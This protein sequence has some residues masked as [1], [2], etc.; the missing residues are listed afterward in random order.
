MYLTKWEEKALQGEFGE[1]LEISM[2]TLV[3]VCKTLKAEKLIEV[4]HAHISGV[5]YFNIGDE[6][7]EFLEDLAKKG[8][9]VSVY[10]S[11]NP[12]SVA[13]I[14]MFNHLYSNEVIAKQKR[15][16]ELL[17]SMGVDE[18]SFTCA[19]Y[20]LRKPSYGEHLAWAESS[21]VAYAN[22]VIGAR[23]NREG[24]ILSLM[25]AIAGRTCFCGMHIPRNRYP[26]E[27]IEVGFDVDSIAL[28]SSLGLY[29]GKITKGVP[30]IKVNIKLGGRVRDVAIRSLL[31]SIATTSSS[32]LTFI[33]G[34]SPE[35]DRVDTKSIERV[36]IDLGDIRGIL[37]ELCTDGLYIGCPHIDLDEAH[38]ILS[39][40][41]PSLTKLGVNKIYITLPMYEHKKL[42]TLRTLLNGVE[43]LYLPGAC[44]VVSNL[45]DLNIDSVATV[46]G[47]AYHYMPK[48]AGARSCLVKAV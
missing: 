48:L 6:G 27:V 40:I 46:H 45:R 13:L 30:Y 5:S 29:I 33:E 34:V 32:A 37:E 7:L 20:K 39:N 17:I 19:P 26:T 41:L 36:P 12:L 35:A 47:K 31:A 10:T 15:I 11:A 4:G 38:E 2:R 43:V 25:A 28:A 24:G 23:T 21:A 44:L 42:N 22:S 14:P 3:K 8:A 1:A 9:H 18:K 16:A